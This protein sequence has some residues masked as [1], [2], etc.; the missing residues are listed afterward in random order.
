MQSYLGKYPGS[1]DNSDN[2]FL[3]AVNSFVEQLDKENELIIVSD[4][5]EITH[6]L[7]YANFKLNDRIKYVYVDKDTPNMYEG[8]HKYYRGLPREVGRAIATGEIIT[9]MDSD[10]FLM[11]THCGV[12][13]KIWSSNSNIK[14]IINTSWYENIVGL[15]FEPYIKDDR[16]N[17]IKNKIKGLDGIWYPTKINCIAL[18]PWL[19]SHRFDV[20]T[21]WR[22][23]VGEGQSEDVVF[24]NLLLSEG[25]TLKIEIPTY[26]K[27]HHPG[28]WDY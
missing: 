28:R 25:K 21:K 27:C 24:G 23:V 14:S 3:R 8:A 20:K 12:L 6:H 9:Y 10:D 4:G 7:Y 5:C 17:I 1:R 11:P 15:E 19:F 2:K 22:D 13:N 16:S 18:A 26:V